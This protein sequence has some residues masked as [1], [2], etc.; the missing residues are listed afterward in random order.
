MPTPDAREDYS[1]RSLTMDN[2]NGWKATR[3]FTVANA[4][5]DTI[6]LLT[7]GI[8]KINETHPLTN[9]L[10]CTNVRADGV[11][12][13]YW[14]ITAQYQQ[15][16]ALGPNNTDPLKSPPTLKWKVGT[17]SEKIDHDLFGMPLKNTANIPFKSAGTRDTGTLFL[18]ITR[19]EPFFDVRKAIN[20][21]NTVNAAPWSP[22]GLPAV[23]S[24]QALCR[25][26]AP[27]SEYTSAKVKYV[28]VAYEFEF[29]NGNNFSADQQPRPD[30]DGFYDG[31][32][33]CLISQGKSG[34]YYG[35]GDVPT[36]G[37]IVDPQ[38]NRLSDDVLLDEFGVPISPHT[39][40]GASSKPYMIQKFEGGKPVSAVPSPVNIDSST[41]VTQKV[42]AA[43]GSISVIIKYWIYNIQDFNVLGFKAPK[44][45]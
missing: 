14:E 5:T 2:V 32:K 18:T 31:F 25:S 42:K 19:N 26:I 12:P 21:Q 16:P 8:P 29:R 23:Q 4:T 30:A 3:F 34:W 20:F 43:D 10:T 24:G 7:A 6:A 37:E 17:R 33:L 40:S 39:G 13:N 38:G 11:S 44:L 35:T 22:M 15:L 28:T 27:V 41:V 36:P 1:R 9:L 45:T